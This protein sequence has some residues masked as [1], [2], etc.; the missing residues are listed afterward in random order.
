M[1]VSRF[2]RVAA[3]AAT[4]AACAAPAIA[5]GKPSAKGKTVGAQL[6]VIDPALGGRV[7]A[8]FT[9]YTGTSRIGTSRSATCFGAGT[10]GSGQPFTLDGPTA[11]GLL[12]DGAKARSS[13]RPVSVTDYY[14][15]QFGP[16]L[17]GVGSSV[18]SGNAYWDLILNHKESQ[19]GGGQRIRGGDEVLWYLSPSFPAGPELQLHLPSIVRSPGAYQA[20]VYQYDAA[21][22]KRTPAAG[23]SV[24]SAVSPTD[25]GGHTTVTLAGVDGTTRGI[26]AS[27]D[28]DQAIPDARRVCIGS[29]ES[30]P[31]VR[32][33][34]FG[35]RHADEIAG[36][37][38]GDVIHA[39][40]G[41]DRV[42]IAAGGS[43]T[44][45]C[46]AG[47]DRVVTRRGDGDDKIGA[48]CEKVVRR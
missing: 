6:R 44:V 11:L 48:S 8:D 16:G 40:A 7:S 30:C 15:D 4:L 23:V 24:T 36:T 32:N 41:D 26:G 13:L 20:T 10:G 45:D 35:S 42:N 5:H 29:A 1:S 18:A 9:A 25:A 47:A 34:V 17:C 22:G 28:T 14:L 19:V 38:K 31:S 33:Q 43:D 3:V 2:V 12:N 39:G 46:G 21:T 37:P 27:R